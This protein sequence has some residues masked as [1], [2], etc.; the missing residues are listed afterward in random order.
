MFVAAFSEELSSFLAR[1]TVVT[2]EEEHHVTVFG[3]SEGGVDIEEVTLFV[4]LLT[5]SLPWRAVT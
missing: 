4:V 5:L 1:R 3:D 2:T